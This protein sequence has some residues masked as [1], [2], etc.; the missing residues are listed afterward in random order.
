MRL[1]SLVLVI[2]LASCGSSPPGDEQACAAVAAARCQR[3][4][5]C[6]T[7]D[8]AKRWSDEA[9]CEARGQL[10]CTA[11]LAAPD[12]GATVASTDACAAAL[13]AE[14]CAALLG[15]DPVEACLPQTGARA[16]GAACEHSAQ[17]ASRFCA[18]ARDARCGTCAP[19]PVAGSSCADAGC[20]PGLVC[21]A[22]T[23]TCQVLVAVNGACSSDLPCA[24]GLACVG[25]SRATG[26]TGTCQPEVA[27]AGGAC[28]PTRA[29]GPDCSADAGLTC[30]TTTQQCVAQPIV[31][32]GMT[33]GNVGGVQTRCAA[34]ATCVKPPMSASGTC[35]APAA[36]GA[37]CDTTN[38]PGC[39]SP[40]VCVVSSPGG[41]AGTCELPGDPSCG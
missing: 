23:M 5:A 22:S 24:N 13:P 32:A 8:F 36:D 11:A 30:D 33:C 40:A 35:I 18:I 41:T 28:D 31:A 7:A 19:E 2:A 10:A 6:S 21:V 17:C 4:A 9:T 3:L 38:G 34:G 15:N 12:T 27:L 26:V 1:A 20:G 29:T 39:L 14:S 16:D 37:A 25:A